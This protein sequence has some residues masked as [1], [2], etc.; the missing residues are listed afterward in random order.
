MHDVIKKHTPLRLVLASLGAGFLNGLLGAGGGVVLYFSL[1]ALY[2][3]DAKENLVTT[4][5][6]VMFFS[7]VSLF[8]YKGYNTLDLREITTVCLPAALGGICGALLLKR[9]PQTAVK[10]IFSAV[11]IISGILMLTKR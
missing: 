8:F 1:G 4:S 5:A 11:L 3:K 6:C 7:F 10:K 9:L 2:G